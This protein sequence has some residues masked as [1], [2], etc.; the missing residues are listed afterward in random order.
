MRQG[1]FSGLVDSNA[2][3]ITLYDPSSVG[4]GPAYSKTPFP[5]NQIPISQISPLAKYVFSVTPLPT[6]PNVNPLVADNYFGVA[7]NNL[8]Q[9]SFTG[10]GDHR[11][12]DKDQIFGR[13]THGLNDQMNRRAFAT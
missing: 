3:K 2:G 11:L 8:N 7:P 13:F 9:R 6:D 4:P 1:G 5:N 12:G 10:R